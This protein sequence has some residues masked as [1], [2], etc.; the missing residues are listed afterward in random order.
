M[1]KNDWVENGERSVHPFEW[2]G[3]VLGGISKR[4]YFAIMVL[5]GMMADGDNP[6]DFIVEQAVTTADRLLQKL[7]KE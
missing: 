5:Q 3:N 4:E 6:T 2:G 7:E 1:A